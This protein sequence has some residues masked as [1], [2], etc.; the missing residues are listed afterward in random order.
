[1]REQIPVTSP[2]NLFFEQFTRRDK[3]NFEW[4]SLN[5]WNEWR[6]PILGPVTRFF[7]KKSNG[8]SLVTETC[9]LGSVD[10]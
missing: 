9:A 1:M 2:C 10:L 5:S 6:G 3:D 4:T 8:G 7:D